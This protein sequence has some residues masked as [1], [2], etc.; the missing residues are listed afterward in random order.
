M[1]I[2]NGPAKE[3]GNHSILLDVYIKAPA[4]VLFAALSDPA[5]L[6]KWWPKECEGSPRLYGTYQFYFGEAYDW[7]GE[8]IDIAQ[9]RVFAIRMTEADADWTG[10]EFRFTLEDRAEDI[11]LHFEHTRWP[12]DNPHFRHSAFCWSLLLNALKKYLEEGEIIPFEGRS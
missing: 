7:R 10:T 9:D 3:R 11:L 5:E 2:Y 8:V 1:D 12:Y 4:N 6:V